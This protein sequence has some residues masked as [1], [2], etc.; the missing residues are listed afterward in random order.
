MSWI[1]E[2]ET[3]PALSKKEGLGRLPGR[4]SPPLSYN[5]H[6]LLHRPLCL[7]PG[8]RHQRTNKQY[9]PQET[10]SHS[11]SSRR[12]FPL[13]LEAASLLKENWHLDHCS[14]VGRLRPFSGAE[15]QAGHHK[16]EKEQAQ[17]V[18][19]QLHSQCQTRV[20]HFLI[21]RMNK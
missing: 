15:S 20:A 14:H 9:G 7:C 2:V 18:L 5:P 1:K 8:T 6:P 13:L 11:S 12:P 19:S 16:Q 10:T 21:I 3:E 17:S 4:Q